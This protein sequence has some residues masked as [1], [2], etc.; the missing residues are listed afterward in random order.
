MERRIIDMHN[1]LFPDETAIES[2]VKTAEQLG[3]EKI[4]L[5]GLEWPGSKQSR[6]TA[7]LVAL[8]RH[9]GL[10]VG[11]GGVNLREPVDPE[12]INML[13][14]QGFS[15]L[16]FIIPPEPYHSELFYPYYRRAEELGM[17]VMFHL[18]IVSSSGTEGVRVDNN[19]MRPIYLDTIARDFR[20]L[21]ILGAHLGNPWYE[22]A[23]MSARWNPNLYFDLTGSTLKKKKP[24]YIAEL[25]WWDETTEYK[26]PF[27]SSA[28]Q[29]IIFGTDV[30]PDRMHD[31]LAD[32]TKLMTEINVPETYRESVFYTTAKRILSGAGVNFSS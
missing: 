6:N 31:V 1:H 30:R 5:H 14:D 8:K 10:F 28:W 2:H 9:P 21:T 11:F 19:F 27:W 17:P 20:H 22:E 32:Y 26:S 16:K 24:G 4:V 29:Q 13:K 7:I 3:I 25:L 23:A 12:R 15:G 18:G